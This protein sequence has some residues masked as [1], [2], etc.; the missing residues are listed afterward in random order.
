MTALQKLEVR[1]GEIRIRLAEIGGADDALTDETRSELGTLRAEYTDVE[2]R[3]AAIRVSDGGNVATETTTGT[4]QGRELRQLVGRSNVGEIFDSAFSHRVLDGATA[5]IQAEFGLGPNQVP[6][7]LLMGA[8]PDEL[9]HRAVTPAPGQVDQN[10]DSIIPYVFP[11]AAGT[12]LG[13][14][15]PT[16]GVGEAAYP[17]LTSKL[18][19]GTPGEN[20]PQTETTGAFQTQLLSPAR[21]QAS[22]FYSREDRA[23]FAGMDSALREN[24][25]GGLSDGLDKQILAGTNGLLTGTHL[26]DHTVNAVSDF[27]HYV[28]ELAY[29]RVDGRYASTAKELRVVMGADTYAHAGGEYRNTSVDRS[30]LDRLMEITGGV[31]VSAHVPVVNNEKQNVVI[32]RGMARDMVAAVWE[33]VTLIPDEI[34]KAANGQIV[35]TAVMLHAVKLLRAGGFYKQQTQHA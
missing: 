23:R 34:T 4:A 30:A 7:A 26:P 13:V 15:M 22:F 35:V 27:A 11:Q 21:L 33:G 17:V 24:L 14:D 19:V 12:F 8:W 6:L 20:N 32:R 5:E 1:A 25:S 31:R 29:G 16:V 28:S 10:Q 3:M 9:E 2:H 18:D